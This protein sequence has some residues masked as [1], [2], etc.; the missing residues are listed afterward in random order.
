VQRGQVLIY[1]IAILA[2][3]IGVL[4]FVYQTGALV[5]Q[6]IRLVDASDAAAYTAAA[7]D[8]R[9]LNFDAYTNRAM[10]ADSVS[11]AQ[12]TSLSSWLAYASRLN[13]V[14]SKV[15]AETGNTL[16]F[17]LFEP[18]LAA[19]ALAQRASKRVAPL[20][21]QL[22]QGMD[23]E[24]HL[25]LMN[26]QRE[27]RY[28]LSLSR[29]SAMHQAAAAA[30]G[31]RSGFRVTILSSSDRPD[32]GKFTY[33]YGKILRWRFG[34]LVRA[35]VYA[36]S[37][38]T[39]RSWFMLGDYADCPTAD[40]AGR[41]DFL[42]RLGG[43][44]MLGLNEWR[45]VD[46]LS[47]HIWVP[48][49]PEDVECQL[50]LEIPA[51]FGMADV[52]SQP[53]KVDSDPLH[54]DATLLV[55]P[56]ATLQTELVGPGK[57]ET[58]KYKGIPTVYGLSP[59]QLLRSNPH[60]RVAVLVSA[61]PAAAPQGTLPQP[62]ASLFSPDSANGEMA[63]VSAAEVDY[64]APRDSLVQLAAPSLYQPYWTARLVASPNAVHQAQGMQGAYLP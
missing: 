52:A 53:T 43:T 60:M 38:N 30:L 4:Y 9:L 64:V 18:S 8:A 7:M 23:R 12:L 40:S 26:S 2:L 29:E 20:L 58:Y 42:V 15:L 54:Y 34:S 24:I 48:A 36:Q 6:K 37:F 1:G 33:R 25:E 56:L 21:K 57:N 46:T 32:V 50:P 47:E 10:F 22:G 31:T 49:G 5:E 51:A 55:N 3:G 63:A 27:A 61:A 62:W 14:Q 59:L 11:I 35:A 17:P 13:D 39:R 44:E 16:K 28:A 45:A 19:A 41:R